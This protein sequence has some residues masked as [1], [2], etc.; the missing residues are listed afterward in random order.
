MCLAGQ[1]THDLRPKNVI[2][3]FKLKV[4]PNSPKGSLSKNGENAPTSVTF[5]TEKLLF[6]NVINDH[7]K[8]GNILITTYTQKSFFLNYYSFIHLSAIY[9]TDAEDPI[10][11]DINDQ[12]PMNGNVLS[13][14]RAILWE[15]RR[16]YN[17]RH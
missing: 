17:Y 10:A 3:R 1:S 4:M 2:I 15:N 5:L 11:S 16:K 9:Y 12:E 13:N 7:K 6:T 14:V 8:A